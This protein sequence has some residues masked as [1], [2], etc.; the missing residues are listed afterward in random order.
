V[1]A[2]LAKAEVRGASPR[3]SASFDSSV[4][5]VSNALLS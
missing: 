5:E 4:A 2:A 3:G 1:H